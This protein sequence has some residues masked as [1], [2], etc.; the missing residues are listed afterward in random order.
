[1]TRRH[2]RPDEIALWR[3]VTETARPLRRDRGPARDGATI[4]AKPARDTR[5]TKEPA[6]EPIRD[7]EIG[8]R[9]DGRRPDHDTLP[10]LRE[11]LSAAPVSMDRKAFGKLRRGKLAPEARIDLHGMTIE[12]AQPALTGFVMRAHGAGKR[13]VLVITGKG[14]HG[15][16]TGPIPTRRGVL[17]HNVPQWLSRPPLSHMVLQVTEAHPRHGGAGAYYVYLRRSRE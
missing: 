10:G 14:R 13:L 1:M 2:L 11:R 4:P 15:E 6:A 3:Q 5:S 17:R 12:R 16:D 9:A 8:E 7:F